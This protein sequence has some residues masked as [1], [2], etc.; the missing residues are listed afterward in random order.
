VLNFLSYSLRSQRKLAKYLTKNILTA[1]LI[2]L[3][4][5]GVFALL[6]SPYDKAE[7]VSLSKLVSEI[8][9]GKVSKINVEGN[10]LKIELSDGKKQISRKE[11]ES[12]LTESL[13][14]YGLNPQRLNVVDVELKSESGTAY[15]LGVMLPFILPFLIIGLFL[16][17]MLRSAQRGTAQAFTFAKAKAKLFGPQGKKQDVTFKDVA[18]AKEAKAELWE[19]VE[20]LKHPKKFLDMG[21]RIPRGV[22]LMGAPGTGKTLLARAVSGE[23][24][25]PFFSI[26]GSEF[27]EMFVG[28]GAARVR[29][30]FETAKKH[31]PSI[32]FVDE[33]DAV[34][35]LRGAGLGGGNDEREQT[36]NQILSEMD[37]FERDTNVIVMGATNRPDV[38]DPALLRPGRFDRRVVIDEPDINARE[39]ILKI[40]AK[41]KPLV[42]NV[43]LRQVAER[44]PGFSGAELANTMN[45]AAIL[46]ARN[47]QKTISQNDLLVSIEKVLLGPERRSHVYSKREKEIAA[48]HEAGHA[49]V[50]HILP[51]TD[52][53]HKISIISRGKAAGYTLKLPIEDKHFRTKTEFVEE[54]AVMLGGYTA[55]KIIFNA[56]T[57]GASNDLEN[58]SA[59]ARKMVT[60]Y[61]MSDKLGPITFGDRQE[62]VFLGKELGE[63]KNYSE[64]TAMEIDKEV[65]KF[66]AN[67]LKTAQKIIKEKRDKLQQIAER[68]VET[69]TIEK[70]EFEK[71]MMT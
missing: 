17:F 38:L 65:S 54:L 57:T 66:I 5:A 61:G 7:E 67:A 49:L 51:N 2:F 39:E 64:G 55:V 19:I 63:Q 30:L 70:K 16:W 71:M 43:N 27:V 31:S 36:L 24:G 14:N 32:I 20:F 4:I 53:V 60:Q 26:S 8:N 21:A 34:G 11:T 58:A 56:L 42:K 68:L 50:A 28:V 13:A 44:T 23:A 69:E 52:P 12:S 45:E 15:W 47:N 29:D 6:A 59:L 46:A 62:L 25:V 18:N 40:H 22:L 1:F 35:R 9:N 37:G 41:G 48:Y 3:A 33:I 10:T